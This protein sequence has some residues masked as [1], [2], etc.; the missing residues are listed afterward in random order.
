MGEVVRSWEALAEKL[1]EG[2]ACGARI[3]TTNGVFDLLHIGHVRYLQAAR[4]R[5][6]LLVVGINSDKGTRALKGFP[7]PFVPEE[8]RAELL[9][10]LACVDFVTIFDEPTPEAL[11]AVLQPDLHVKGGDYHADDLPETAVVRRHGGEVVTLPFIAG[12]ST[13]G[14]AERIAAIATETRKHTQHES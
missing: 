11:L 10:A 3:V 5:G 7:R 9:A 14:L 4:A 8:E 2:R 12:R 6:D 13:T 1:A